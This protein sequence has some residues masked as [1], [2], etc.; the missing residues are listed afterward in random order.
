MKLERGTERPFLAQRA[1]SF[2]RADVIGEFATEVVFKMA[3]RQPSKEVSGENAKVPD[4]GELA[5]GPPHVL[6]VGT[7][8]P[9]QLT[10]SEAWRGFR[11]RHAVRES[12]QNRSAFQRA[13]RADQRSRS[14]RLRCRSDQDRG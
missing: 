14:P 1:K 5:D 4:S 12:H 9:R 3:A 13:P 10:A 7:E 8:Q 11:P 2:S 6:R